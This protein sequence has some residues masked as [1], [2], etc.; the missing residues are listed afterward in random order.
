MGSLLTRSP[1]KLQ[2]VKDTSHIWPTSSSHE[3]SISGWSQGVR[4]TWPLAT[5]VVYVK[6]GSWPLWPLTYSSLKNRPLHRPTTA[7]STN[8]ELQKSKPIWRTT[9]EV[10]KLQVL[11]NASMEKWSTKWQNVYGWKIQVRKNWLWRH[12]IIHKTGSTQCTATPPEEDR[13]T[14]TGNMYKQEPRL[15]PRNRATALCQLKC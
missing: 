14:A 2:E 5:V 13:T 10:L 9:Q 4:P 1:G 12:D 11:E 7:C 8:L 3:R 6:A 15:L